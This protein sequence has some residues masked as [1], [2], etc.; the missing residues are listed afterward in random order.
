VPKKQ[1]ALRRKQDRSRMSGKQDYE[2]RYQA[3]KTRNSTAT[4]KKATKKVGNSRK[5]IERRLGA[6]RTSE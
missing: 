4:V 1:T 6:D 5:R 3:R 2:V